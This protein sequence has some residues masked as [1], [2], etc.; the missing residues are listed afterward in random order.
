MINLPLELTNFLYSLTDNKETFMGSDGMCNGKP[1][2]MTELEIEGQK[3]TV[4]I[5]A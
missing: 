1:S 2:F 4:H 3:F 5:T